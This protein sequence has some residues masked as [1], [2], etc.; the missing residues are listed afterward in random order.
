VLVASSAMPGFLIPLFTGVGH[1]L[2]QTATMLGART[3]SR[4]WIG[5][6]AMEPDHPLSSSQRQRARRIGWKLA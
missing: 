1:T 5:L 6:S 2:D 4:L 3:V